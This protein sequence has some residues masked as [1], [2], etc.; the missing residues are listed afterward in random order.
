MVDLLQQIVDVLQA[1]TI[2]EE[3]GKDI[4]SKFWAAYKKVSGEFDD[5]MLERCNSNMDIILIFAGLFSAIN[6]SF[7]IAMQPNSVDTTN[8]LLVLLIQI[9]LYGPSAAQS[10]S[11]SSST[12]YSSIFWMQALAYMSLALSLLAAFGAVMGKQW[13]NFYKTGRY[14][15]GSLEERCKQRH[16]KYKG[17]EIWWFEGMLQSFSDLLKASLFLFGVSLAGWMWTLQRTISILIISMTV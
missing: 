2:A 3:R 12:N 15:D 8:A 13:L 14:G 1:S 9:T 10:M 5:N 17:L 6:T 7:I 11:L 16:N 4:R